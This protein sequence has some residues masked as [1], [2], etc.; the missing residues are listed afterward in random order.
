MQNHQEGE[1][2]APVYQQT[3]EYQGKKPPDDVQKET[4]D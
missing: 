4:V 1:Q 3:L 2:L